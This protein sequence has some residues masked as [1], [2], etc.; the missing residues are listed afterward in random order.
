MY[1]KTTQVTEVHCTLQN[2]HTFQRDLSHPD[3]KG[4]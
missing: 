1:T 2:E 3:S 4:F